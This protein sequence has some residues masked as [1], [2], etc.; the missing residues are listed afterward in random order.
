V[1]CGALYQLSVGPG[2]V[3]TLDPNLTTLPAV[4]FLPVN[5]TTIFCD[6]STDVLSQ[7]PAKSVGAPLTVV[8][9]AMSFVGTG[10]LWNSPIGNPDI[11]QKVASSGY[12]LQLASANVGKLVLGAVGQSVCVT[13][14]VGDWG[15]FYTSRGFVA[16]IVIICLV[17]GVFMIL[18]GLHLV[19]IVKE[20]K[21]HS[22]AI[23]SLAIL[24]ALCK[25][26]KQAIKLKQ[27]SNKTQT[28]TN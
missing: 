1:I 16:Y 13:S 27:T 10:S 15:T 26:T 20:K 28:K 4:V 6:F 22:A 23:L 14:G 3:L 17:L 19:R 18:A 7:L 2:C 5:T 11:F 25:S 9:T 8:V 12:G 21:V 24:M